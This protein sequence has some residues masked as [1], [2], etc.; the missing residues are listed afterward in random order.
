[1]NSALRTSLPPPPTTAQLFNMKITPSALCL[2]ILAFAHQAHA[3]P[4]AYGICQTGE[5]TRI[6]GL[7]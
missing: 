4:I 2:A 5:M 3:G 6:Y 7:P 1:M